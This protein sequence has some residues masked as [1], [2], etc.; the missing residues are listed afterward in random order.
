MGVY[1]LLISGM[2]GWV[3]RYLWPIE[4][5]R[6]TYKGLHI[7]YFPFKSFKINFVSLF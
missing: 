1:I 3:M 7:F 2:A 6:A 4:I 5:N